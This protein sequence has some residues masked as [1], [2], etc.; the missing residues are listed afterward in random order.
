MDPR[1]LEDAIGE[2]PG[3][4]RERGTLEREGGTGNERAEET[5]RHEP[6]DLNSFTMTGGADGDESCAVW[7]NE[8]SRTVAGRMCR[9]FHPTKI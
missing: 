5:N 9:P 1:G 6:R 7:T 3:G 8:S 2:S 4:G